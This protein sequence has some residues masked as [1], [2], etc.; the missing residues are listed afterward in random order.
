VRFYEGFRRH[1]TVY[2]SN[3]AGD[4]LTLQEAQAKFKAAFE[5]G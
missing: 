4:E 5:K 2:E 3:F 1:W